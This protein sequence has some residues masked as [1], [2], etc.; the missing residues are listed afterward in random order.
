MAFAHLVE[1]L[2]LKKEAYHKVVDKEQGERA[3]SP[4]LKISFEMRTLLIFSARG[5][6]SRNI[7]CTAR[8][9]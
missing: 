3:Q 1:P 5:N 4:S 9:F 7:Y 6:Q 8:S 2:V